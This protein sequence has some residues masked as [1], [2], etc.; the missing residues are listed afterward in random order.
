MSTMGIINNYYCV[1]NYCLCSHVFEIA[2]KY[3]ALVM[4]DD[5]HGTG[6]MGENLR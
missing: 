1:N 6:V 5:C 2:E 3:N 4:L